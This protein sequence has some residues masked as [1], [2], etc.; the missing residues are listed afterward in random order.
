MLVFR[1]ARDTET[2]QT[3]QQTELK[4]QIGMGKG[5]FVDGNLA[6]I[7]PFL[8]MHDKDVQ[9]CISAEMGKIT[10]KDRANNKQ[11]FARLTWDAEEMT[12]GVWEHMSAMKSSPG[13]RLLVFPTK[14]SEL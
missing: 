12:A 1:A 9:Q 10:K 8:P 14:I 5:F 4:K 3:D 13:G 2:K 6:A 7:V 11:R